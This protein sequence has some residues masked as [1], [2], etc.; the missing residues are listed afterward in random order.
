MAAG[1]RTLVQRCQGSDDQVKTKR[2]TVEDLHDRNP[3]TEGAAAHAVRLVRESGL[4]PKQWARKHGFGPQRVSL[5]VKKLAPELM[6]DVGTSKPKPRE[7][8]AAQISWRSA[9]RRRR[10]PVSW[11][12]TADRF[13]DLDH[14]NYEDCR[15]AALRVIEYRS[16]QAQRASEP[17]EFHGI[18]AL[19]AMLGMET[20]T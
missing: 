8:T 19:C 5:W 9:A 2:L 7:L 11:E 10:F 15:A 20:Q 17:R 6:A 14:L 12:E 4:R 1:D 3:W 13:T 18:A 16:R